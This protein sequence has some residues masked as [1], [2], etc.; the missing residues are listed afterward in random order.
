MPVASASGDGFL[1]EVRSD[2]EQIRRQMRRQLRHVGEFRCEW[3]GEY[4]CVCEYERE[5]K[6]ACKYA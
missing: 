4:V 5:V 6:K 2:R 1:H 3:V